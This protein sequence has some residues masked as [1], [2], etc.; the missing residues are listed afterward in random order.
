M[1]KAPTL[2]TQR[3]VLRAHQVEDFA[4]LA[5]LWSDPW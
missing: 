2:E 4:D 3:L 5:A 1:M